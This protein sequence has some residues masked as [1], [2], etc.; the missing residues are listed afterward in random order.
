MNGVSGRLFAADTYVGNIARK[1]PE[2]LRSG[3]EPL[4]AYLDRED[5]GHDV[6]GLV[7]TGMDVPA[8]A[9]S[10]WRYVGVTKGHETV[11]AV[12]TCYHPPRAVA[13]WNTLRMKRSGSSHRGVLFSAS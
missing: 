4:L 2:A 6:D 8:G 1:P 10:V 7:F 11:R 9:W 3:L 13:E 5:A 12:A